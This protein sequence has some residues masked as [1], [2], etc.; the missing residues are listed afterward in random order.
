MIKTTMILLAIGF[1]GH[2][3]AQAAATQ[4]R[5]DVKLACV[6][7]CGVRYWDAQKCDKGD[8]EF[9]I[10]P[11]SIPEIDRIMDSR[12]NVCRFTIA[13]IPASIP[14]SSPERRGLGAALEKYSQAH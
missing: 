10:T 4:T 13:S 9:K 2:A 6:T 5:P 8:L 12:A 1:Q 14:A 3:C 11:E 7:K